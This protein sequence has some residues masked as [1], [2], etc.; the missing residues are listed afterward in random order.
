MYPANKCKKSTT[1]LNL[2]GVVFIPLINVKMPTIALSLS[3]LVFILLINVRVGILKLMN[4]IHFM[5][6]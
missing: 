4:R 6:S 3:G 1:A 5:L 2:T